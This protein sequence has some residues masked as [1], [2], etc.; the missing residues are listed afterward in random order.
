MRTVGYAGW[1]EAPESGKKKPEN[2]AIEDIQ[3]A[4]YNLATDPEEKENLFETEP[5][6]AADM[7]ARLD[8]YIAAL[9]E[10][11]YPTKDEAGN[12]SNFGGIWHAGWC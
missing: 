1:E 2:A 8:E 3:N 11:S 9:S 4:L 6:V 10:G 5:E 12:P 7:R